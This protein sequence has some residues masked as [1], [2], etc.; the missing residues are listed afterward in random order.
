M[1]RAHLKHPDGTALE[2]EYDV[3]GPSD[4]PAVLLIMG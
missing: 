1:P 4:G 2:I 3:H